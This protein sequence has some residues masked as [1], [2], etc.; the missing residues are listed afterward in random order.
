MLPFLHKCFPCLEH[1]KQRLHVGD[2][3][4]PFSTPSVG[5]C[6]QQVK[7]LEQNTLNL[8]EEIEPDS[9]REEFEPDSCRE[10]LEPDSCREE[11]EPGSCR[12]ESE[13]EKGAH[14]Q[15][16]AGSKSHLWGTSGLRS[17]L[18]DQD[19]SLHT[20]TRMEPWS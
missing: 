5:D 9:C 7:E 2:P 6:L 15:P 3:F 18:H 10:E 14:L 4:S 11:L 12:E 13:Q 8:P 17:E 1:S 20:P 19:Q 16:R